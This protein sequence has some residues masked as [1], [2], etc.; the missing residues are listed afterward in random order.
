[1]DKTLNGTP[2][3]QGTDGKAAL[4]LINDFHALAGRRPAQ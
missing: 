3:T 4:I 1:M 2:L